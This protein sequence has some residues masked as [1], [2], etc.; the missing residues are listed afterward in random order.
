MPRILSIIADLCPCI[1]LMLFYG[2][3][4][5]YWMI[6]RR[7]NFFRGR[8]IWLLSHYPLPPL[9][10]ATCLSF[11]VC[12]SPIKLTDGKW[13]EGVGL[14]AKSKSYDGKKAWP[15]LNHSILSGSHIPRMM[16]QLNT[17]GM[18]VAAFL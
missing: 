8:I 17:I 6:Y 12:V 1:A 13:W 5:E 18:K 7:P 4:R 16:P 3:I 9:L 2:H 15:S 14:G 10:S 11:S